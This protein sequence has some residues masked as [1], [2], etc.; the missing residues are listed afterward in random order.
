MLNEEKIRLMTRLTVYEE[1]LGIKDKRTA[2][3]FQN[4]YVLSGLIGSFVAGTLAWGVCAAVYCGYFFE[5]IFFSVYEN[6]LGS[7]LQLAVTSYIVFILLFLA[8][9]FTVYYRKSAAFARRRMMYEQ[10]LEALTEICDREMG[11]EPGDESGIEP[12]TESG[13]ELEEDI[14]VDV[15]NYV[16]DEFED[17]PGIENED[18]PAIEPGME[19]EKGLEG[20]VEI[21]NSDK[22]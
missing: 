14:I 11:I 19:M 16:A 2:E 5:E 12:E 3:Y 8:F 13:N 20:E 7:Y 4:D 1:G 22:V 15:G 9:T 21:E 18:D 6:R 10:D 17:E